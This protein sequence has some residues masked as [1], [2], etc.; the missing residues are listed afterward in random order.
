MSKIYIKKFKTILHISITRSSSGSIYCS[1]VKLQ[2]KT[3]SE[4]VRYVN[5]GAVAARRVFVCESCAVSKQRTT[6]TQN[7]TCCHSAKL[8]IM[9]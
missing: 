4:L 8:N 1:L 6:H 7:T 5:F 2:F 3:S 9:K